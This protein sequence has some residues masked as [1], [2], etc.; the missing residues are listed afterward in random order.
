MEATEG[1]GC[2]RL[3]EDMFEGVGRGGEGSGVLHFSDDC[4]YLEDGTVF[5]VLKFFEELDA[6]SSP[7]GNAPPRH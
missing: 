5:D 4:I 6:A 7:M 3:E 1:P 2:W